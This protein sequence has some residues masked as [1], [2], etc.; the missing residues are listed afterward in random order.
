MSIIES[1]ASGTP[2]ISV[3]CPSGPSEIIVTNSNGILVENNNPLALSNAFN[4]FINDET[5]YKKCKENAVSSVQHLD[6]NIVA[7]EW[8]NLLENE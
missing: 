4:T 3:D 2:V 7:N 8:K 6:V 5:L 1:L